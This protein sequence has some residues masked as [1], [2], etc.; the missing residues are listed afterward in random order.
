M[1]IPSVFRNL[2]STFPSSVFVN[3]EEDA[4]EEDEMYEQDDVEEED[5]DDEG[6][7]EDEDE[8]EEDD[9]DGE[10]EIEVCNLIVLTLED[11]Y[12]EL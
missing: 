10:A 3:A 4:I 8:E 7:V 5:E 9:D 11:G 2:S 6:L 12:S 1:Y